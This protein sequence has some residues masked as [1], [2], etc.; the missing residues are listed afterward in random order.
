MAQLI[1]KS[2]GGCSI[3]TRATSESA[4]I[5]ILVKKIFYFKPSSSLFNVKSHYKIN[6]NDNHT[7]SNWLKKWSK[8]IFGINTKARYSF[9]KNPWFPKN[10]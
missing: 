2:E 7:E 5:N 10:L 9:C 4:A 6:H 3:L 8:I 1:L